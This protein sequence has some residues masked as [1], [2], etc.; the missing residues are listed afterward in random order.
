VKTYA[1]IT[2]S[3]LYIFFFKIVIY[4]K[5]LVLK[6]TIN[7]RDYDEGKESDSFSEIAVEDRIVVNADTLIEQISPQ[8]DIL[9][10]LLHLVKENTL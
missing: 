3:Q 4:I 7:A 1:Q 6:L 10:T 2:F 9:D 5:I 8:V